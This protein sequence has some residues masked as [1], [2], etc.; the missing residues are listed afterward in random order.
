MLGRLHQLA[1]ALT[2]HGLTVRAGGDS[3]FGKEPAAA[4][5][6]DPRGRAL[7]PGLSQTVAVTARD[8]GTL[9]LHLHLHWCWSWSGAARR[10]SWST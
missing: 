10:W 6:D 3:L 2:A 1:A 7:N 8:D 9:H 4:Q 5:T